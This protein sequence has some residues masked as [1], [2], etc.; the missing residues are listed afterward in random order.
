MVGWY[1][2]AEWEEAR[3]LLSDDR[4]RLI[5]MNIDATLEEQVQKLMQRAVEAFGSIDILLH[6]AGMVHIG[7]MLWETETATWEKLMEVNLKSAFLC[8]KHAI[9]VMLD[10]K[11]GRIVFFPAQGCTRT[12]GP[13]RRLCRLQVRA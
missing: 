6:M 12:T 8:S 5:D 3:G 1:A 9:K 11:S 10:K 13:F 7:P 2:R 4:G